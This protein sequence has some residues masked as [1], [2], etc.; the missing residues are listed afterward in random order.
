M[1]EVYF[2]RAEY[3]YVVL[4]PIVFQMIETIAGDRIH[5][6]LLLYRGLPPRCS[7]GR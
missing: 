7:A 5:P 4:R 2:K 3:D 6:L 1:T